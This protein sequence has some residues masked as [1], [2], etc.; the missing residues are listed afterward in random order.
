MDEKQLFDTWK[1]DHHLRN[2]ELEADLEIKKITH[3][4]SHD[5]FAKIRRNIIVEL[6]LSTIVAIGFPF[7]FTGDKLYFWIIVILLACSVAATFFV[8]G[9]YLRD[10]NQLNEVSLLQ[11][12]EKKISILSRYVRQLH[13]YMYIIA[14]VSFFIGFSYRLH[15]DHIELKRWIYLIAF[16]L[17]FLVLFM[18]LCNRY[19]YALYG[20]YLKQVKG[21]FDDL[22]EG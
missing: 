8:Y 10:M 5:L 22:N 21:L 6:A 14:P 9:R 2:E 7:F 1:S 15:D 12:L 19:V 16:S 18:W 17:P 13:V 4:K 20:K 3:A 11:S